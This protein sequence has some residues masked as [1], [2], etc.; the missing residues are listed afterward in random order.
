MLINHVRFRAG[1]SMKGLMRNFGTEKECEG[2]LVARR[3]PKGYVCPRCRLAKVGTRFAREGR[4]CWQRAGSAGAVHDGDVTGGGKIGGLQE[5]IKAV[6][7]FVGNA[8]QVLS[9]ICRSFRLP[10]SVCRSLLAIRAQFKCRDDLRAI[11]GGLLAALT[12]GPRQIQGGFRFGEVRRQNQVEVLNE[13]RLGLHTA[14]R[15]LSQSSGLQ[16]AR[17]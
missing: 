8:N 10:G 5:R 16:P 6:N 12:R 13:G 1:P 3:C 14:G 15:P 7:T 4:R 9:D 17:H 2:A 11:L